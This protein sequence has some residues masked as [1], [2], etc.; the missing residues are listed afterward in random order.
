MIDFL[1]GVWNFIYT[2]DVK[3]FMG[4]FYAYGYAVEVKWPIPWYVTLAMIVVGSW[5]GVNQQIKLTAARYNATLLTM[6]REAASIPPAT[7]TPNL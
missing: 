3:I 7:G 6:H 1:K 2:H 4:F 5:V